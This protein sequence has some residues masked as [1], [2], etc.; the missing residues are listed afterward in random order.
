MICQVIDASG[1]KG[2]VMQPFP[3]RVPWVL[4]ANNKTVTPA[5]RWLSCGRLARK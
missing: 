2:K 5:S 4:A 1:D 3:E